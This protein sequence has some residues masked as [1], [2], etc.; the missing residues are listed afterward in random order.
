MLSVT[1]GLFIFLCCWNNIKLSPTLRYGMHADE[2]MK[3]QQIAEFI[4]K[5]CTQS[6]RIKRQINRMVWALLSW[7]GFVDVSDVLLSSSVRITAAGCWLLA[8]FTLNQF[9]FIIFFVLLIWDSD[10]A[11][12]GCVWLNIPSSSH[13]YTDKNIHTYIQIYTEHTL[14]TYMD[15]KDN[16]TGH[17]YKSFTLNLSL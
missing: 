13:R 6:K 4:K 7:T 11:V 1:I 15:I 10:C 14:S 9:I 16:T 3:K 8:T 2:L 5:N 12:L 17:F